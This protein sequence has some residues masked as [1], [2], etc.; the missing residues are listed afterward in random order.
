MNNTI[1][2][3]RC[4]YVKTD[5]LPANWTRV[6]VIRKIYPFQIAI[7]SDSGVKTIVMNVREMIIPAHGR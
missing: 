7:R 6:E 5:S 2:W 4:I 1:S 3:L